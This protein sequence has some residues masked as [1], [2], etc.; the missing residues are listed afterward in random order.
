M[1]RLVF[2]VRDRVAELYAAPFLETT[3]GSATRAFGDA[4]Q[5][6]DNP[7]SKHP[8]DFELW[9]LGTFEDCDASY[10]LLPKPK[11]VS[12]GSDWKK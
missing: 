6:P 2:A 5:S 12:L 9:H 4:T 11:C 3:I 10:D 1:K 7:A 8:D